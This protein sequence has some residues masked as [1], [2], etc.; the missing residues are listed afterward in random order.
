[1]MTV[2]T[3]KQLLQIREQI[4][5]DIQTFMLAFPEGYDDGKVKA[6][7]DYITDN[8]CDIVVNNFKEFEVDAETGMRLY[9][10]KRIEESVRNAQESDIQQSI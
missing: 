3:A 7:A 1:M 8:L 4:Q 6:T 5:E 2:R 10:M 9:S